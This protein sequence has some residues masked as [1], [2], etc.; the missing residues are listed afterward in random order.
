MNRRD[1]R[2]IIIFFRSLSPEGIF[3]ERETFS[4]FFAE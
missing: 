1:T 3:Y 4:V 2:I